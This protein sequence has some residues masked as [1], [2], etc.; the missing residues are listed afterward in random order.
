MIN[1]D[2]MLKVK[3]TGIKLERGRLLVS[4]P[5]LHDAFFGR[6]VIL[7]TDYKPVGSMG[8]ILNKPTEFYVSDLIEGFPEMELP[9]FSG[10]PVQSDNIFFMHK[11]GDIIEDSVNIIGDLYWGGNFAQAQDYLIQ[12]IIQATDV[13]FFIGYAGW[14]ESQLDDEL[15]TDSWIVSNLINTDEALKTT[16]KNLW[17]ENI[18]KF[19]SRYKNWVNFPA[20]PSDN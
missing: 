1:L 11:R 7:M 16:T 13:K 6:S 5:L 8:F 10:G 14:D 15:N 3:P 19:G 17:K 12:G 18:D 20:D 9:L 2:E 4:G